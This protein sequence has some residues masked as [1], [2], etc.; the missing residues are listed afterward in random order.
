MRPP[1]LQTIMVLISCLFHLLS[2][3]NNN[4][5][6]KVNNNS[7]STTI[8]SSWRAQWKTNRRPPWSTWTS[9]TRS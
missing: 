9:A 6:R 3:L 8:T 4:Q 1:L 5:F 2:H 7:K